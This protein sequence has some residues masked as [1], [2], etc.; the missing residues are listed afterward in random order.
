M[1]K[2]EYKLYE[3]YIADIDDEDDDDDAFAAQDFHNTISKVDDRKFDFSVRIQIFTNSIKDF[4]NMPNCI[5]EC[6][7]D[8]IDYIDNVLFITDY[9]LTVQCYKNAIYS[10]FDYVGA[11]ENVTKVNALTCDNI[12]EIFD[13]ALSQPLSSRYRERN[14]AYIF[15]F[16]TTR[17][18]SYKAVYRIIN[19]VSN[20]NHFVRGIFKKHCMSELKCFSAFNGMENENYSCT[21]EYY[22]APDL[23]RKLFKE[24]CIKLGCAQSDDADEFIDRELQKLQDRQ[25]ARR[26][27]KQADLGL[28]DIPQKIINS[29]YA[30]GKKWGDWISSCNCTIKEDTWN[31]SISATNKS[32]R[33]DVP[34]DVDITFGNLYNLWWFIRDAFGKQTPIRIFCDGRVILNNTKVPEYPR[35]NWWSTIHHIACLQVT[36]MRFQPGVRNALYSLN[37]GECKMRDMRFGTNV[38]NPFSKF[39][40][41]QMGNVNC[42]ISADRALS[43]ENGKIGYEADKK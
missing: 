31:T 25:D 12:A 4:K 43:I 40:P 35:T 41:L 13:L 15:N 27:R 23:I 16:N 22:L 17:I 30:Q 2:N 3:A 38:N 8:I 19:M 34:K 32:Y 9:S 18:N 26:G 6:T 33:I 1:N 36:D 39:D 37:I 11:E 20:L 42:K 14:F 29:A 7:E 5:Q 10:L 24:M 28:T 21:N